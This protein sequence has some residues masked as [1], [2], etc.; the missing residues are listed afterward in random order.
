MSRAFL[1]NSVPVGQSRED[2]TMMIEEMSPY[3]GNLFVTDATEDVYSKF[4]SAWNDFVDVVAG[5][6]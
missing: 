2:L 1:V 5:L 6:K 4:G 3:A